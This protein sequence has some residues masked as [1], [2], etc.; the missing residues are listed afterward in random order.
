M[1][2]LLD[3]MERALTDLFQ[4]GFATAGPGMARRLGDLADQCESTGL[5]T[6]STLFSELSRLLSERSH[7]MDK[8]DLPLTGLVCRAQHYITLCRT[9]MTGE[10]IRARWQEGGTT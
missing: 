9:R 3:D 5:H 8:S 2:L 7:S 10:D 1:K 6:G 4:M